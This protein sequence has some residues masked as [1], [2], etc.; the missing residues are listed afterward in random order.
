[1]VEML[2]FGSKQYPIQSISYQYPAISTSL[3]GKMGGLIDIVELIPFFFPT[4]SLAPPLST[5]PPYFIFIHC[6]FW[7]L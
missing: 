7:S 3:L 2:V 5:L 4:K 6:I 1:M